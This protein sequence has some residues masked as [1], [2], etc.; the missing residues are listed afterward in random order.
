MR[1]LSFN[2]HLQNTA[3]PAIASLPVVLPITT[4]QK[5][6]CHPTRW[7]DSKNLF[8]HFPTRIMCLW[9][10]FLVTYDPVRKECPLKAASWSISFHSFIIS[11]HGRGTQNL[12]VGWSCFC[13]KL[14]RRS[15]F[16][17]Q[18][19]SRTTEF[20]E[21][22][23]CSLGL[24]LGGV[25]WYFGLKSGNVV[26]IPTTSRS[27]GMHTPICQ[28]A[29]GFDVQLRSPL[30]TSTFGIWFGWPFRRPVWIFSSHVQI[31]HWWSCCW[32]CCFEQSS[33][34]VQFP[35][36]VPTS[37]S[38]SWC[39]F[40][41]ASSLIKLGRSSESLHLLLE[42]ANGDGRSLKL[43]ASTLTK[44]HIRLSEFISTVISTKILWRNVQGLRTQSALAQTLWKTIQDL[45][46]HLS[47]YQTGP[48]NLCVFAHTPCLVVK[49]YQPTQINDSRY[50]LSPQIEGTF[51][52]NKSHRVRKL[53]LA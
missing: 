24:L 26:G 4:Y 17:F 44:I 31:Q 50:L 11:V 37:S 12:K 29:S 32:F 21:E 51:Y 47:T 35:R 30:S 3:F 6:V 23:A 33:F 42:N 43:G 27:M 38:L 40:P 2:L 15:I 25:V 20:L 5:G 36:P 39:P 34:E 52:Q 9:A 28:P 48:E 41:S 10:E 18:I 46:A 19:F 45:K 49:Q 53:K 14:N 8:I 13:P 16:Q 1:F 22:L 7:L